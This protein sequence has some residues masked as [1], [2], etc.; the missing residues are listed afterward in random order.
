VT[1]RVLGTM[2]ALVFLAFGS[3]FATGMLPP[4]P[5]G[6]EVAFVAGASKDLNARFSTEAAA[7]SAGFFRYTNEDD[8][9]AISYVN[10]KQWTSADPQHPSQLWYSVSGKLLG[11]DFSVPYVAGQPPKRWGVNP[12]RW[13][14]FPAHVHWV[15]EAGGKEVYGAT[16]VAK[17]KAAG[18]DPNDPQ[19]ATVVA[20]GKA[21]SVYEVKHVFLFPSLWDVEIWVTPNP[22]GAFA[23]TN[24]LVHP[25]KSAGSSSM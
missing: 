23:E 22:N 3:A 21:K 10:L 9:G 13:F 7:E 18:G 15:L 24:P 11:A 17:F 20:L 1:R 4:K 12:A 2:A 19:P 25:T 8:T 16:S 5:Q 14:H 6:A